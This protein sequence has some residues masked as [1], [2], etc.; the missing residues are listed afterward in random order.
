M[1]YAGSASGY[2]RR[3]LSR[4]KRI[5]RDG[6]RSAGG[7]RS[8]ADLLETQSTSRAPNRFA[9]KAFQERLGKLTSEVCGST[10]ASVA[11]GLLVLKSLFNANPYMLER[12]YELGVYGVEIT[13]KN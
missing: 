4:A 10:L 7:I 6:V 9:G 2:R 1:R 8:D 5:S 12:S 13:Y 11:S 3:R